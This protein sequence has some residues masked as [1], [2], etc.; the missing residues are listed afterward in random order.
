[1]ITRRGLRKRRGL[2][3]GRRLVGGASKSLSPS[4][5]ISRG[6]AYPSPGTSLKRSPRAWSCEAKLPGPVPSPSAWGRFL[7]SRAR[8]LLA[9]RMSFFRSVSP[10]PGLGLAACLRDIPLVVA[11]GGPASA[12]SS[13]AEESLFHVCACASPRH[14]RV[15]SG[16]NPVT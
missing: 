16:A 5:Q 9:A 12:G 1:M 6:L 10:L 15:L 3:L 14:C 13:T 11:G 4:P 7:L 8:A 2:A